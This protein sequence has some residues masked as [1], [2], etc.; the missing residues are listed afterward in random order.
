M[1]SPMRKATANPTKQATKARKDSNRPLLTKHSKT[2]QIAFKAILLCIW[3]GC[4]IFKQ[5]TK[6]LCGRCFGVLMAWGYPPNLWMVFLDGA[7]TRH[8]K[9]YSRRQAAIGLIVNDQ[10]C[11]LNALKRTPLQSM[12]RVERLVVE[13]PR[14]ILAV[15]LPFPI[16]MPL[17]RRCHPQFH[18]ARK[19]DFLS[20]HPFFYRAFSTAPVTQ[21][22]S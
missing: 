5:P 4:L 6:R 2:A 3:L 14:L 8:P 15:P 12:V 17:R 11:Y 22:C 10:S 1:V 20:C 13:S 21:S 16:H 19:M 7:L 9:V 18:R